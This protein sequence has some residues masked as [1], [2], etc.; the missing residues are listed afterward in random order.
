M[1]VPGKSGATA[2]VS[3]SWSR[4]ALAQMSEHGIPPSPAHYCVWYH[5]AS[6]SPPG[7]KNDLDRLLAKL[8]SVS[9]AS[10]LDLFEKH[11]GTEAEA[12]AMERIGADLTKALADIGE[13]LENAGENTSTFADQLQAA[14]GSLNSLGDASNSSVRKIVEGL[15]RAT[16][17]MAA[18]NR[19]LEESLQTSSK[20]VIALQSH[21]HQVRAEAMTDALTGIANRRF[22][23]MRLHEHRLRAQAEGT[24][25]SLM[26]VD[27]D[28][29]KRFNDSH[30]HRVG[31]QVLKAVGSALKSAAIGEELPARYGGEEFAVLMPGLS[32]EMALLRA[33]RLRLNLANQ[34]LRPKPT[35]ESFGRITVSIGIAHYRPGETGDHLVSRADSALYQA[36]RQGRNRVVIDSLAA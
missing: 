14:D 16:S 10:S 7:L 4:T 18:R 15:I 20:Q 26:L 30:G 8:E 24:N 28:H 12:K 13:N 11:F 35:G 23:D 1:F 17:D 3:F 25:L 34:Y 29:F 27:I 19:S 9:A 31:D 36:K 32:G 33:E 21:L 6:G 22:F 5:Y 2:D